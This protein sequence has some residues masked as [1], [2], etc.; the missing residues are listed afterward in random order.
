M[1]PCDL[2]NVF[3]CQGAFGDDDRAF[4]PAPLS[5]NLNAAG[6]ASAAFGAASEIFS[7]IRPVPSWFVALKALS[8]TTTRLQRLT[9]GTLSRVRP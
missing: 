2:F 8:L 5:V 4:V 6:A 1:S 9:A 7:S 3:P